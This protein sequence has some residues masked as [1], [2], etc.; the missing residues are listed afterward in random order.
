[1][2]TLE[3]RQ[4]KQLITGKKMLQNGRNTWTNENYS[5]ALSLSTEMD[6]TAL[7]RKDDCM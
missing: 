1:M 6:F 7:C 5:P 4:R 3:T 2:R